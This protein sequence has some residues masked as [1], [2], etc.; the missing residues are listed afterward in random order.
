MGWVFG[1]GGIP[2]LFTAI[3][4]LLALGNAALHARR[5]EPR[6]RDIVSALGAA[7][8]CAIG[9]AVAGDLAGA[10]LTIARSAEGATVKDLVAMAILGVAESMAPAI[11]GFTLLALAS[12]LL[13]I[14]ARRA[15]VT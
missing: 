14:G 13:A 11:L 8:R 3:F 6:R 5:P 7:T 15:I 4:G 1:A 10:F 12:M 9:A 2:G